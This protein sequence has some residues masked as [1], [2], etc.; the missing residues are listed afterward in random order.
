MGAEAGPRLFAQPIVELASGRV[1]AAEALLRWQDARRGLL[2]PAEFIPAAERSGAIHELG[3]WVLLQAAALASARRDEPAGWVSVN[4]SPWQLL[5]NEFRDEVE[6]AVRSIG[7]PGA[8][9]LE[10]TEN[11]REFDLEQ[12]AGSLHALRESGARFAIDDCDGSDRSW[13]VLARLPRPDLVKVDRRMFLEPSHGHE[14]QRFARWSREEEIDVVAEGLE[15][16]PHAALARGLGFR[17]GQGYH[18]A[19]PQPVR[20]E[21]TMERES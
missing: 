6:R 8:L 5:R 7:R 14:L 4:V 20:L 12:V 18:F 1:V 11:L 9:V 19:R 21:P 13:E 3:R 15:E 16:A 10:I 2:S 17:Y